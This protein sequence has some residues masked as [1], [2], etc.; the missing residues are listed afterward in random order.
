VLDDNEL[1]RYED[2]PQVE[3]GARSG[4]HVFGAADQVGRVNLQ[5]ADR[6]VDAARLV[7]S[8]AVFALNAPMDAIQPPMF[9][10]ETVR[11]TVIGADTGSDFDDRLDDFNPQSS[12]QWDSLA[13]IGFAPGIFYNGASGDDIRHGRRNTIEHWAR[14]GIVGRG[15]VLDIV[16]LLGGVGEGFH[17]GE[18]RP[19]TVAELEEAR[20]R[21]GASWRPGDVMIL[22]TGYLEWYLAQRRAAREQIAAAGDDLTSV[23]LD[24]GPEMLAYLWDSGISAI[25]ADNPGVEAGPFDLTQSGWPYGFLHHCLIGQLGM[26]LG[27]LWWLGELARSCREDGRFEVLFTAAPCHV[28]GGIGSPANA[29][30]IK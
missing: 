23:G 9:G 19:I 30:A 28:V 14:R 24:R 7:R 13:H 16:D 27:E 6:V 26:A 12:S 18:T 4:W 1:P 2:L 22:Y 17:P 29:L 21:I 8:G 15:I 20:K 5:T 10:R 25:G 11:H 3:G